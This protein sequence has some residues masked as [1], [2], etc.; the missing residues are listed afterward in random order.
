M[1]N[2]FGE[3]LQ[4][5][6][7]ALYRPVLFVLGSISLFLGAAGL[8]LPVVPTTPFIIVSAFCFARSSPRL[9]EWLRNHR[10]FGPPLRDWEDGG[11]MRRSTKI[12]VTLMLLSS[13]IYPLFIGEFNWWLRGGYIALV[14]GAL[15]FIWTRPD[16]RR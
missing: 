9:H 15:L 7:K 2:F 11:A 5:A 4:K 14:A 6:G 8:F 13:L 16:A 1:R 3:N 12:F 10:W